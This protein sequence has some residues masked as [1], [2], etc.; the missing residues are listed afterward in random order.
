MKEQKQ[1]YEDSPFSLFIIFSARELAFFPA[2][3]ES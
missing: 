1:N 3:S 2:V